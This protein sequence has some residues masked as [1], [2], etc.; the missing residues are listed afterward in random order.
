MPHGHGPIRP[1]PGWHHPPDHMQG[2][3]LLVRNDAEKREFLVAMRNR[4][5][6]RT[7][8]VRL[9]RDKRAA[10]R[11]FFPHR[12]YAPYETFLWEAPIYDRFQ[13]LALAGKLEGHKPSMLDASRTSSNSTIPKP[14]PR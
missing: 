5:D 8:F 4:L 2:R 10:M 3:P 13:E 6:T 1:Y 7:Q 9:I 11:H 12:P 14:I